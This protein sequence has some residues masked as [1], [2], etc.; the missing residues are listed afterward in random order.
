MKIKFSIILIFIIN[1][2]FSQSDI[3]VIKTY[4]PE[5]KKLYEEYEINKTDSLKNGYYYRYNLKGRIYVKGAY[6]NGERIG[7]W[8]FYDKNS[9][10]IALRQKYDY[11]NSQEIDYKDNSTAR[12]VGGEEEFSDFLNSELSDTLKHDKFKNIHGSLYLKFTVDTIGN[13]ND[14]VVLRG[15]EPE[16]DNIFVEILK[17]SPKWIPSRKNGLRIEEEVVLPIKN[18]K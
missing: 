14:I 12:F 5:N 9:G 3:V 4:Y 17:K 18:Y 8:E 11:S 6:N 10:A 7:I 2:A 15:V 13:L 16:Y 1:L